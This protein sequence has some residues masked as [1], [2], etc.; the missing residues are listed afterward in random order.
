[1]KITKI[2]IPIFNDWR[3]LFILLKNIDLQLDGWDADV[4][5]IVINDASTEKKPDNTLVFKNLSSIKII[6]MKKNKGHT[7]CIATGLKY[8]NEKENFDFVVP[9]DG[10]GED[11]PSE[12]G[13][14]LCKAYDNPGR[15]IT[16]NR[17]KRSEGFIF[18]FCYMAHK[19]LTFILTGQSIKFG[20]YSCLPKFIVEKMIKEP[21]TWSSFSGSLSKLENIRL[22]ISSTRGKRYFGP[23]KM[24]FVNLLK[25]SFS[26]IAVFKTTLLIRSVLFLIAYLFLITGNTSI[27]TLI[28]VGG[29]LIMM[30]SVII[31]SKRENISEFNSSLENIDSID[32]IK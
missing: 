9:M 11:L 17:V 16:G 12:I 23:S 21:A 29:V 28:P 4:S 19:Y 10:D 30:I 3:S 5:V 8:I 22:S 31:L 7:R 2:L 24:S 32:K 25:H 1:M 26:I 15:A 20:N 18:R 13:P 27:V 14:I 6:N